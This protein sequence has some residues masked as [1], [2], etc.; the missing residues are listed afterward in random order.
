MKNNTNTSKELL[1]RALTNMPNDFSLNEVKNLIKNAIFKIETVEKKRDKREDN[2]KQNQID[3]EK[4]KQASFNQQVN[5]LQAIDE[6]IKAE[7]EKL[8]KNKNRKKDIDDDG[9]QTI[10]D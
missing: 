6:M 1:K 7:Q 3:V 2:I 4:W 8:D 5:S 10:L 9:I